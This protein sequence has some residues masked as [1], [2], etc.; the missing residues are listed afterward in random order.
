MNGFDPDV[1]RREFMKKRILSFVLVLAVLASLMSFSASV[2]AAS[3]LPYSQEMYDYIVENL[4]NDVLEIDVS[5]Y[6]LTE[7]Q[8][9]VLAQ[10]LHDR[11]PQFFYLQS[12]FSYSYWGGY[13]YSLYFGYDITDKAE[14]E[15][16][17]KF[18][19]D[20]LDAI[21]ETLPTGL[22]DLEKALYLHDYLCVNFQYD[23]DYEI[24]DVYNMFKYKKG[25]C[26]AYTGI[27]DLLLERVGIKN[28][29]ASSSDHIWNIVYLDGEWYH[30]DV[31]WGDPLYDTFGRAC[32]DDFLAPDSQFAETHGE[33]Y[34]NYSATD[35][36]YVDYEW[37][38][39]HDSFGFANGKTYMLDNDM[40]VEVDLRADAFEEIYKID[41]SWK[42]GK[43]YYG[44]NSGFGSYKNR[45][46]FNTADSIMYLEPESGEVGVIA[47]P[48][49]GSDV[50]IFDL[51]VS[52]NTVYYLYGS[53]Y[54]ADDVGSFE[55]VFEEEPE[56]DTNDINGDGKV[57]MFDY[58]ALKS[59]VLGKVLLDS[60]KQSRA[61]VNGDGRIN[62]FDYLAV[63]TACIK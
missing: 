55:I 54:Y 51:Y 10:D 34:S 31:T 47:T 48:D 36:T 16:A 22:D 30:I 1:A 41:A 59:H 40:I 46:I 25:V 4:S 3:P 2:S 26:Q 8:A 15:A 49:I 35:D 20:E 19:N 29:T 24:Y 17:I 57:N 58:V 63:K 60:D 33:Y 7:E 37:R 27:Y 9:S 21:V 45:L 32:H 38:Y 12:G 56:T 42:I 23:T 43:F 13:V 50:A 39:S 6:D 62:M 11:E 28:S 44:T 14:R 18:V 5:D 61:D 52:G 53:D